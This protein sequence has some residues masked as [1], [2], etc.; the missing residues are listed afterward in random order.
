MSTK[1]CANCG[2]ILGSSEPG[3]WYTETS[4]SGLCGFCQYWGRG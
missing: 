4:G 1:K 2:E 3:D